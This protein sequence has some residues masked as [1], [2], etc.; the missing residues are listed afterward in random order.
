MNAGRLFI[1]PKNAYLDLSLSIRNFKSSTI[2]QRQKHYEDKYRDVIRERIGK[3]MHSEK[4]FFTAAFESTIVKK[5]V[6]KEV[7]SALPD[8]FQ[9]ET[10]IL[11]FR[12]SEHGASFISFWERL[13]HQ[14]ELK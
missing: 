4:R 12:L 1:Y 3:N 14:F 6:A 11:L 5:E 13:A 2:R 8:R 9:L 7:M 10:P